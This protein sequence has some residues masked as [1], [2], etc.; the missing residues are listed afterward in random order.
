MHSV[1]VLGNLSPNI[2]VCLIHRTAKDAKRTSPK[3]E[4]EKADK[5]V[6]GLRS[7]MDWLLNILMD[8]TGTLQNRDHIVVLMQTLLLTPSSRTKITHRIGTSWNN[9]KKY[10]D[11]AV[12]HGLIRQVTL[13]R[14]SGYDDQIVLTSKGLELL[15]TYNDLMSKVGFETL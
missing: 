7:K 13:H 10:M 8:G 2:E 12:R 14:N 3:A 1:E 9:H 6:S 4:I 5:E 15:E 11:F